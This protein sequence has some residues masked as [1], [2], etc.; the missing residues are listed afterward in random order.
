MNRHRMWLGL[1]CWIATSVVVAGEIRT[2]KPN[3]AGDWHDSVNWSDGKLPMDGDDVVIRGE[4][5]RVELSAT[6]PN[7]GHIEIAATLV[8][9][10]WETVLRANSVEVRRGGNVTLPGSFQIRADAHRIQIEC[11]EELVI[12]VG[13]TINANG[14]GFAGG[15]GKKT[16]D[17]STSAGFGPGAGG[18]PKT[19]GASAGGSYAGRGGTPSAVAAYGKPDQPTL[20]G[21]G[22]GGGSGT[23]GA[24]GGAI[25]ITAKTIVVD[26][27]ISANGG[28]VTERTWSGGGSGG[29]IHFTC[30]MISGAATGRIEANGG[31]GSVYAGGGSGGRIAIHASQSDWDGT[32]SRPAIAALGGANGRCGIGVEEPTNFGEPGTIWLSGKGPLGRVAQDPQ[33]ILIQGQPLLPPQPSTKVL[34]ANTPTITYWMPWHVNKPIATVTKTLHRA[35]PRPRAAARTSREY[36]GPNLELMET[37]SLEVLDDV[38][39][40][41]TSRWS[42]D[43]GRTWSEPVSVQASNNVK[44]AG[45]TVWEGGGPIVFDPTSKRL[46]QIW[47]RQIQVGAL[48]HCFSYSRMSRDLGRTW[49]SPIQMKYEDGPDFDPQ[50]PLS[51]IFLDRNEGYFG[52]NILVHLSGMLIHCLAHTNAAGDSKNNSRPWRMGSRLMLGRWNAEREDYEWT[53]GAATETTPDQSARGLMEPEVA[54]L[55]DGKLLVVWRGS[56]QGWDGTKSKEPGRKWYSISLDAGKS[57]LPVRAWTYDDGTPFYSA[58]SIHRI[59]RHSVT[60]KLYW[61]GNINVG[62]PQG[63]S[64]RYPLLIAEVDETFVTLKKKTVTAIDDRDPKSHDFNYQLSNFSLFENRETHELEL[65]LTTYGQVQGQDNWSTADSYRYRLQLKP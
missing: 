3:A 24:G 31:W 54:E 48:Y 59:I 11:A 52:N 39:E 26:G 41:I 27:T 64:P 22:G 61:I 36:V 21:S 19:W 45:V 40:N 65:F 28:D 23:G 2:W 9:R 63:N 53:S 15:I 58:S 13:G 34:P 1:V 5:S 6:T 37:Q 56:D 35:H 12:A 57:F 29:S 14:L 38:G 32:F 25:R 16:D 42:S 17:D 46:V 55:K 51:E 43:N 50:Q 62:L 4:G 7:F 33:H 8:M 30:E 60:D 49:L 10:G 18:Y 44:H 20:P 47:L